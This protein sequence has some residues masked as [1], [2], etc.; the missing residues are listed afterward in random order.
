MG[1]RRWAASLAC[2]ATVLFGVQA[3]GGPATAGAPAAPSGTWTEVDPPAGRP[4]SELLDVSCLSGDYCLASGVHQGLGTELLTERWDGTS[5]S[6]LPPAPDATG[7]GSGGLD[8]LDCVASDFC[9]RGRSVWD[10]AAWQD[11]P[12]DPDPRITTIECVTT[13]WCLGLGHTAYDPEG[14]YV[15]GVWDGHDWTVSVW[16][17]NGSWDDLWADIDCESPTFCLAVSEYAALAGVFPSVWRWDGISWSRVTGWSGLFGDL[18]CASP[19][20]CFVSGTTLPPDTPGSGDPV[21]YHWDGDSLTGESSPALLSVLSCASPEDCLASTAAGERRRWDGSQWRSDGSFAALPGP[22]A[23]LSCVADGCVTVGNS[24]GPEQRQSYSRVYDGYSWTSQSTVNPDQGQVVD[25]F[26]ISCSEG[27]SRCQGLGHGT[28]TLAGS[29]VVTLYDVR[30]RGAL[31]VVPDTFTARD[32]ACGNSCVTVGSRT[33]SGAVLPAVLGGY[34]GRPPASVPLPRGGR[35]GA[36]DAVG[37]ASEQRCVAVGWWSGESGGRTVRRGLVAVR[38]TSLGTWSS[39]SAPSVRGVA[40]VRLTGVSCRAG[41]ACVVVG[42]GRVGGRLRAL[43]GSLSRGRV[44]LA[45]APQP[46]GASASALLAVDCGDGTC[47]AVGDYRQAGSQH[48][49]LVSLGGPVAS[50]HWTRRPVPLD[51][52]RLMAVDCVSATACRAV[53]IDEGRLVALSGR[54]ARWAV[55]MVPTVI[56]SR[57]DVACSD[58]SSCLAVAGGAVLSGDFS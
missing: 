2:L 28:S 54:P 18:E 22:L 6:A 37:C 47:V 7:G 27:S 14:W 30:Q 42:T 46:R 57:A 53:G 48:P 31:S 19:T 17:D 34:P 9:V 36:L 44:T 26:R 11:F 40:R 58:Q 39:V 52:G 10:G 15:S 21:L 4:N 5:W 16:G 55:D 29:A 3:V 50:G 8:R 23:S 38:D 25:V 33:A 43:V 56:A 1:I 24:G 32:I 49:F 12:G 13:D 20:S 51:A 35:R 45:L 41:G